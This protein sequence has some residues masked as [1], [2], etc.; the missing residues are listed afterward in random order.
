MNPEESPVADA[1]GDSPQATLIGGMINCPHC[2]GWIE[3]SPDHAGHVVACP[4]CHGPFRV[5]ERIDIGFVPPPDQPRTAAPP[6]EPW[7][8]GFIDV[9]ARVWMGLALLVNVLG[10]VGAAMVIVSASIQGVPEGKVAWIRGALIVAIVV[11]SVSGLLGVILSVAF[12][13]LV[14]DMARNLRA[15]R[16]QKGERRP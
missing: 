15:I 13:R 6:R 9:Y 8:Y 14:V 2:G 1:P 12:L 3:P 5:P 7:F 11:V 16:Y 10:V 4:H